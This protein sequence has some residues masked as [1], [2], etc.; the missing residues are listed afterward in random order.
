MGR[1]RLVSAA[2]ATI[3]ALLGSTLF[4]MPA[5]AEAPKPKVD[6]TV[7]ATPE[8][9]PTDQFIVK[10]KETAGTASARG[11]AYGA[12]A[13]GLGISV[14]E[15]R[16]MS[17]GATVVKT[18]RELDAAAA[19]EFIADLEAEPAVEYVEPDTMMFALA[20]T[21]NDLYYGY[22]W[23]LTSEPYGLDIQPAWDTSTGSGVVVAVI[24]SGA[25]PHED[26]D[27]NM[28]PGYDMI[29][30]SAIARDGNGRDANP[31]DEGTYGDGI[32]CEVGQSSWHGAH[33]AGTIAAVTGNGKGVAGVAPNAKVLPIRA[34]GLCGGGYTSD[35]VDGIT[36]ASGGTVAGVPAN[37]NPARVI[38]L[39]LG[40]DGFCTNSYQTA[41]DAAVARGSVIVA[42]AGNE[43]D[44]ASLYSPAS[45]NN[46]I[47]V[48]ATGRDG[49]GAPYSNFGDSV[50]LSAPG[51]KVISGGDGLILSTVNP[52]T[53]GPAAGSTYSFMQGT[54]MAAPH[55]AG[56]A[57][58]MLSA[59]PSLTSAKVEELLKGTVGAFAGPQL[60]P[61]GSGIV[62]A[63]T[64]VAAAVQGSIPEP[65]L[66]VQP[67]RVSFNGSPIVGATVGVV[68]SGWEP[69]P[70]EMSY[71]WFVGDNPMPVSTTSQ[72][73]LRV[74]DHRQKLSVVAT[75]QRE[76]YEP[77]SVNNVVTSS[78][79]GATLMPGPVAVAGSHIVGETLTANAGQWN[80]APVQLR[81]EWLRNG[82]F[83]WDAVGPTYTLAGHDVG[84]NISVRVTGSKAGYNPS[85]RTSEGIAVRGETFTAPAP[86]ITGMPK[87]G[88]KLT[89]AS[90]VWSPAPTATTYQWLRNGVPIS[91]ATASTYTLTSADR[92]F[93]ISVRFTGSSL[94]FIT[95]EVTSA[96]TIKV[97][98][99]FAYGDYTGDGNADVIARRSNDLFIHVSNGDGT[100]Q[101]PL[102]IG[103]GF[104][105]ATSLIKPGDFNND[106]FGDYMARDASGAL[107]LH[108]DIRG[109]TRK[110]IGSGWQN[111]AGLH[112]PGDFNGDGNVDVIARDKAGA[113]FLYPGNG[114]GGWLAKVK[115]GSGWQN[116]TAIVTP[117]DFNGDGA[118]DMMARDKAGALYLYPGNGKG[119][120]KAKVKIGTGWQNFTAIHGAGD[121]NRDKKNDIMVRDKLGALYLYP[122][123][124]TG[125]WKTKS[126]IGSGWNGQSA[127]F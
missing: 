122:G 41:I 47:S 75:G 27:A 96:P 56:V 61:Y 59:N 31:R 6:D 84:A 78:V 36:W 30:S 40:G 32:D 26:L 29:V 118:A 52:G 54:S 68:A 111:F 22:Q 63:P 3:V 17:T 39:S 92:G 85:S 106:G 107:W 55:V 126:K 44:D 76:G 10:F 104:Q 121:F 65:V 14:K 66:R 70:V 120:W 91:G 90:A 95:K 24:D 2:A 19:E 43:S 77:A 11:K 5:S 16:A 53:Q 33:V 71:E 18:D 79:S 72:Y 15:L 109:H 46:V 21:P 98:A 115:I 50:D 57:A 108:S 25:V 23:D 8:Q 81:Y 113:L 127:I 64:A 38:N 86:T 102:L 35:I 94:G 9:K 67:G 48:G 93:A 73:T 103:T 83:I 105:G 117:G 58:L 60:N 114:K 28:L 7:R 88:N 99:S 82:M 20:P 4:A 112:A 100:W 62:H 42:A 12:T 110:Q 34:L 87:V 123:N 124:G 37:M 97:M 89:A 1:P 119:G 69:A 49:L 101:V 125:G 45:C 74:E 80:P 13:K 116:F 51:G